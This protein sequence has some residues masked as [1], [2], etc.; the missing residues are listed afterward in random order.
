MEI[1]QGIA[2]EH[3]KDMVGKTLKVMIEGKLPADNTELI[4]NQED[5][6]ESQISNVYIGRTYM[7]APKVDGYIFVQ[8]RAEL[9][10]GEFVDVLVTDAKDYDL[11]GKLI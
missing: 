9:M 8:T 3:A 6:M 2:F 7:D 4:S 10:S 1:Q 11:V 5:N